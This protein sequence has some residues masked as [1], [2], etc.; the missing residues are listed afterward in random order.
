MHSRLNF[1]RDDSRLTASCRKAIIK[2]E[3]KKWEKENKTWMKKEWK[4]LV[5]EKETV[6][7]TCASML[8]NFFCS[9]S[10]TLARA[11]WGLIDLIK[12]LSTVLSTAVNKSQQYQE[13]N[14]R[15]RKESNP[16]LQRSK[17]ATS[18]LCSPPC[19]RTLVAFQ[20]ISITWLGWGSHSW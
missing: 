15:E 16:G 13:K 11:R 18:R 7:P 9:T 20:G 2:R 5:W 8:Q 1:G 10:L 17:C 6:R 12:P 19:F 4:Q 3:M 14:S